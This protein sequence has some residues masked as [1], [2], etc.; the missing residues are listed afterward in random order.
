MR[1]TQIVE[2]QTVV[3]R[4]QIYES[5]QDWTE[6]DQELPGKHTKKRPSQ[7]P[8]TRGTEQKVSQGRGGSNQSSDST[9]LQGKMTVENSH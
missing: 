6:T 3:Y 2:K 8:D 7:S 5:L 9:Q 1:E 4:L